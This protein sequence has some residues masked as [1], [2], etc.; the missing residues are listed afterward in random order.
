MLVQQNHGLAVFASGVGS[1]FEE[2]VREGL[3]IDFFLAD[4]K[5]RALEIAQSAGIP[6]E[7]VARSNFRTETKKFARSAYTRCVV[8]VLHRYNIGLAAMAGFMTRLGEPMFTAD[9]YHGRVLNTHPSLL[10]L[11]PG[12]NAV[13]DAL[14]HPQRVRVTGCTVHIAILEV[15]AGPILDQEPVRILSGDTE[16]TLHER[17]KA[18]ERVLYPEVIRKALAALAAGQ[19]IESAFP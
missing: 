18:V 7:L 13:Q 11:F 19:S 17:I 14:N 12:D 2:M 3:P 10:P 9:A 1:L 4:R 8:D 15:D 6:A 5:C 16:E